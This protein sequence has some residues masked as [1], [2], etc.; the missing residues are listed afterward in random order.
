MD[1]RNFENRSTPL[2]AIRLDFPVAA[3]VCKSSALQICRKLHGET[4]Q[5][6]IVSVSNVSV[7]T[8]VSIPS[9][10]SLGLVSVSASY[11]S[12]T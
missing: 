9:L 5:G 10:Q 3:W 2:V 6:C 1:P 4:F 7:S 12:F 8:L 11:V